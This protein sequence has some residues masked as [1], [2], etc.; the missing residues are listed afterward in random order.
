MKRHLAQCNSGLRA[1]LVLGSM[2]V[3]LWAGPAL[4]AQVRTQVVAGPSYGVGQISFPVTAGDERRWHVR[5]FGISESSQRILF[6]VVH[7]PGL[8]RRLAAHL[9]G[10]LADPPMRATIS[11]LFIGDAPLEITLSTETGESITVVPEPYRAAKHGRLARSWWK[12]VWGTLGERLQDGCRPRPV[13]NYVAGLGIWQL[14]LDRHP[15]TPRPELGS[16]S[17]VFFGTARL[18]ADMA[19]SVAF[20]CCEPLAA[21]LPVPQPMKW[22]TAHV[23]SPPNVEIEEIAAKVPENCFYVRFGKYSN[24]LWATRLLEDQGEELQRLVTLR[25]FRSRRIS[26]FKANWQSRNF[27]SPI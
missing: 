7:S 1:R 27:L 22:K 11:F 16:L 20:D 4:A 19:R 13:E 8:L 3:M 14:Q 17:D 26:K 9:D 21:E 25:G 5:G 23:N 18:H 6:P 10:S 24:L 12:H 2:L 15:A